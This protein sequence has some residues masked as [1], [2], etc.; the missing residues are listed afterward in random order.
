MTDPRQ[1]ALDYAHTHRG[2]FLEELKQLLAIPSISTSPTYK[3]N[4]Q[5]ASQWVADHLGSMQMTGVKVYP[6]ESH[7]IVYAEWLGAGSEAPTVLIYGH[8]DVQPADPLDEW[9]TP[10]FEPTERNHNLYARGAS[11]MKGQVMA[12]FKAVEAIMRTSTLPVNVKFVIEGEEEVGSPHLADFIRE[13]QKLLACDVCLNTDT[14]ML[15]PDKPTITYALRGLAYFE[16][17][18]YGASQDLHSGLYGGVVH[19]P[20]QVLCELIA[21]MH[22]EQGQVTL[23]GFYD[24]V[25]PLDEE[26]RVELSRLPLDERFYLG[27]TGVPQLWGEKGYTPVERI[28]ARPTLEVNGIYSG[29]IEEGAKTVL[30]AFAMAK[31]STRLV[32]NQEPAEVELQ[33]REYLE[34]HAPPTV[35]W[36]LIN[37]IGGPAS[38]SD[39][40]SPA[41]KAL[42]SAQRMVWGVPPLFKRE[43]GSVPVVTQLQEILGVSSVNTGFGLP[44]DHLHGPNEKLHLPTWYK[45]IDTLIHFLFNLRQP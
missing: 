28:G 36:E 24:K 40:N 4:M 30:P 19:N 12:T 25:L 29:F 1:S 35:R 14:G 18:L 41:I 31:I 6:P 39:R 43:G 15:A 33:L 7:P 45:G 44:D 37:M 34:N 22:D 32:P 3:N 38:L 21:G 10:P 8:Y 17:H 27:Q 23:P 2:R 5:Q 26:E 11:D 20:A 42:S 16:L 9:T 13:H